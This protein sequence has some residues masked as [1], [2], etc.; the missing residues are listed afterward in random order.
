MRYPTLRVTSGDVL[1]PS[2]S[3]AFSRPPPTLPPPVIVAT[4]AARGRSKPE[5]M[6]FAKFRETGELSDITVVVDGKENRLHKFPLFIKSDFFRVLARSKI[7]EKDRVELA[8]FPG[9]D[10]TFQL[11]ANYCYNIKVRGDRMV[12]YSHCR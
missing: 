10:A 2:P 9:G 6:D 3:S 8:D 1:V 5:M 4:A 11:V 7:S 12:V